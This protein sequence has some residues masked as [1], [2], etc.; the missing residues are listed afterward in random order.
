[1]SSTDTRPA[2][3]SAIPK[4]SVSGQ[5]QPRLAEGLKDMTVEETTA[6]LL[7]CEVTLVNW[8]PTGNGVDYLYFDRQLLDF[9]KPIK[10][11]AGAGDAAGSI[12]EGRIMGIEGRYFSVRPPELLFLAE[13][14]LQDLR[15]T[16]RTRS[17]ESVSDQDVFQKIASEY[18]LQTSLDV[19]GPQYKTL[20]QVNQSDLA[21]LR[22]RARAIDAELWIDGS[23]LHVQARA[24]RKTGDVTLNFGE[25][26]Y[27]FSVLADL[28][29]QMSGMTVSGWD[30]SGKQTLTYRADDSALSSELNGDLSGTNLLQQAVGKR[31]Q[32]IVHHLPATSA[33]TQALAE[34]EYRR[35]ARRFLTGMGV[36][37]GDSRIHVG[38][39]LQLQN[40]GT[41]FNGA[42]YVTRARHTFDLVNGYRTWFEVERPGLGQ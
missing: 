17:F 18:G 39:K 4:L 7:H 20:S 23:T 19:T 24:R 10:I 27:E 6:G 9:G 28:A 8:G 14:R 3:Y 41:I 5:A 22:E 35:A 29:L 42:Y 36:S 21:F 40:L 15:M 2:L 1:M 11:E 38:T 12:F 31:D 34:S 32:Q 16:R 33:E 25:R 30:V 37:E 26:L 13:D